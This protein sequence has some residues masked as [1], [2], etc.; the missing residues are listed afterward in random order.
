M[1]RDWVRL[2]TAL[3][4]ARE[5]TGLTQAEM[6]ERIGVGRDAV[7]SIEGGD[8]KRITATIKAYAR[9]VGWTDESIRAVLDGGVP[10]AVAGTA[11]GSGPVANDPN[12]GNAP[13]Y[14]KGM[15]ARVRLELEDGE[16]LD[17]EVIDLSAPGSEAALVMV[18]KAG[19]ENA[20]DEQKRAEL[21]RW[22]RVQR[23]IRQI[24]AEELKNP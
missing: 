24:V 2:G 14:A 18:V 10:T 1:E 16:V 12:Y 22:A 15:P 4:D 19:S 13:S 9:E 8:S 3:R 23:K 11:E 6:G 7:R 17:A 20:S 5:A 21:L